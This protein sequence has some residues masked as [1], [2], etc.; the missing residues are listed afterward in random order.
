[1]IAYLKGIIT[2]KEPSFVY[3]EC[4]GVGYHVKISLRTYDLIQINEEFL[5]YTYF[6]VR[7]DAHL[8]YGFVDI[9]EK[10]LFEL[11][12]NVN[13]IGGNT[14]L[15]ILSAL[16]IDEIV[17]SITSGNINAIK[18]VRGIGQ[19]TAERIIL[20]LKDKISASLNLDISNSL[21]PNEMKTSVKDDALAALVSLGF[22]KNTMEKKIDEIVKSENRQL[23]AE[24]IIRLAL[25]G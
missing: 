2:K 7:E 19:K 20:E 15:T 21:T 6:Q 5:I 25:K 13:G 3:L 10:Q 18:K 23:N 12:L 8:L 1:M 16:P 24:E 17:Q 4:G 11:L 22:Q 14:A 9:N